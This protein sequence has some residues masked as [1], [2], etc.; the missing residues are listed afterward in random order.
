MKFLKSRS[1]FTF[2]R[3][4][5]NHKMTTKNYRQKLILKL[6]LDNPVLHE[7]QSVDAL[8]EAYLQ[9]FHSLDISFC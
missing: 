7:I 6:E 1:F 8:L 3:T 9:S 5:I 2:R 4:T